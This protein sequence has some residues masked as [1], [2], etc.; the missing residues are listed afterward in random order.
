LLTQEASFPLCGATCA[1]S[2]TDTL[3]P[4]S[5]PGNA[6]FS[7][8]TTHCTAR[9]ASLVGTTRSYLYFQRLACILIEVSS[10]SRI[11]TLSHTRTQTHAS[12]HIEFLFLQS[13]SLQQRGFYVCG[14]FL[15]R[16]FRS[17]LHSKKERRAS[18]TPFYLDP[19]SLARKNRLLLPWRQGKR[20]NLV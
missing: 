4:V 20:C 7:W 15:F 8:S 13:L 5:A 18:L 17:L 9:A 11:R 14:F 12:A 6:V 10:I 1:T 16:L 19:G 2:C 3:R